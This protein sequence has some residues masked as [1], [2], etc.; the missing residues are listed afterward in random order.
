MNA[1]HE[2]VSDPGRIC[3]LRGDGEGLG[4]GDVLARYGVCDVFGPGTVV[5]AL[6]RGGA[7]GG[8]VVESGYRVDVTA[9]ENRGVAYGDLG[10]RI[11]TV[12]LGV[13]I[14]HTSFVVGA[15]GLHSTFEADVDLSGDGVGVCFAVV[16]GFAGSEIAWFI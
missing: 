4:S 10:L 11:A 13:G 5:D 9:P 15:P 12:A 2:A 3:A 8:D 14:S 16:G 7:D 6:A 1:F